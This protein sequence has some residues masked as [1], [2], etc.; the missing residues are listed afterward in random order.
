MSGD[1]IVKLNKLE[2]QKWYRIKF[3]NR[4]AALEILNDYDDINIARKTLKRIQ[5]S[6][7]KEV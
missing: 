1:L 2:F 3:S 6:Q 4:F 7:L 5:K